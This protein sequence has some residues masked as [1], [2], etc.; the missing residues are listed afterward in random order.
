MFGKIKEF[1]GNLLFSVKVTYEAARQFFVIKILLSFA[2]SLLPFINLWIWK[3]IINMLIYIRDTSVANVLITNV[4]LY[5]A[6]YLVSRMLT[7]ASEYVDYQYNDRVS[8]YVEN[9][10]LDKFSEVDLAFYDS[11][12]YSDKLSHTW[13]IKMYMTMLA[14]VFFY[15]LE[16]LVSFAAAFIL[17]ARLNIIFALVILVLSVP[18]F[19]IRVKTNDLNTAFSKDNAKINREISYFKEIFRNTN[20]MYDIK[21]YDLKD[22][23]VGKYVASWTVLFKRRKELTLKLGALSLGGLILT[24]FINQTLLYIIV[25]NKLVKRVFKIGD[26]TYFISL[27]AQ[28]QESLT[29]LISMIGN[30]QQAYSQLVTIREFINSKPSIQKSGTLIPESFESL[31]FDHVYFTYPGKKGWVLED[32]SFTINR[33]QTVGLV[34]ENGSGKS[35]IAKLILRLYD[36]NEGR[37]LLNGVDIREYAI[38]RYRA[39]FSALFQDFVK[40]SFTLR[41]NIA[42]SDYGQLDNDEKILDAAEKSE[43]AEFTRDWKNGIDTPLTRD[44]EDDGKELSGG[45]WQRIALARVFFADRSFILLDEPSA[46][47]DVFAEEKIFNQFANLS[48]ERTSVIISHRLSSI[49][50]ADK[51]IVLKGGAIIEEGSHKELLGSGGYYAG[52]FGLQASR[53]YNN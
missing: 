48:F 3:N 32:C 20:A 52:L 37:I 51:I 7:R 34:G 1:T 18:V 17:I 40:Y 41:E 24:T 46:S 36:V 42:L 16:T 6:V 14:T 44:F 50:N 31:T 35:T 28:Y 27:Y 2:C 12:D 53:Y 13:E 15:S 10:L 22:F 25:I 39:L 49:V 29:N 23:F 19:I 38:D 26:A 9:I 4:A 11:S 33:G 30:I 5:M 21:L 8:I 47:L 43:V 45:Q